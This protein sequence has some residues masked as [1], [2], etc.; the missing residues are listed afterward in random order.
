MHD[1]LATMMQ[2]ILAARQGSQSRPGARRS[3]FSLIGGVFFDVDVALARNVGF[4]LIVVVIADEIMD[5]VVWE[6]AL[7]LLVELGGQRFV[8]RE[9]ER[10]FA[11]PLDDVGG[12][13][14]FAA[15]GDAEQ[16]LAILARQE[17]GGQLFD[18]RGLIA[19]GLEGADEIEVNGHGAGIP[20]RSGQEIGLGNASCIYG[21]GL[22]V[23][24]RLTEH[25]RCGCCPNAKS[26]QL[27]LGSLAASVTQ[28]GAL[29]APMR[30]GLGHEETQNGGRRRGSAMLIRSVRMV[31]RSIALRPRVWPRSIIPR[32][33]RFTS[34]MTCSSDCIAGH[35][36]TFAEG[37]F[38]DC[39]RLVF[40]GWPG[41]GT[42]PFSGRS[43]RGLT[44]HRSNSCRH[45][46]VGL[47]SKT[48]RP[49]ASGWRR[50]RRGEQRFHQ[51]GRQ[52]TVSGETLHRQPR[53]N[54]Y[55]PFRA[56]PGR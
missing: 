14:G 50:S 31:A 10:R 38:G 48:P 18:G 12:G 17:A 7:E 45:H 5:G 47:P 19:G 34:F 8:V 15:A 2:P 32:N 55:V 30:L 6:K 44:S 25:R 51:R 52:A 28:G 1:T 46:D 3:I 29:E 4:G 22:R 11:E 35:D 20:L 41:I 39:A 42:P 27:G 53:R 54:D 40:G 13:E 23:A 9:D 56:W 49:T 24:D 21:L 33:C 26:A 43:G 36:P 37:L 16:S